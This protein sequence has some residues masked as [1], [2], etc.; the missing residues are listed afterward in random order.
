[1]QQPPL[2]PEVVLHRVIVIARRNG[3][4]VVLIASVL[5]LLDAA[6]GHTVRAVAGALAAGAGIMEMH[7]AGLLRDGHKRGM[8]WLV[9]AELLLLAIIWIFCAIRLLNP[10]L[11]EVRAAFH[12]SLALPLMKQRWDELQQLGITE[13]AYLNAVYQ[14]TYIM[15]ALASLIYQGAMALYYLRRHAAVEAA[16]AAE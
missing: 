9:R 12:A 3:L 10:D 13:E 15:L 7:G 8:P 2:L 16:L 1:M 14:L 11:T 5:A 6:Q 4:S